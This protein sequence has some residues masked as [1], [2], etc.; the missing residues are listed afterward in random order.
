MKRQEPLWLLFQPGK[1]K[2][3]ALLIYHIFFLL[4]IGTNCA[5]MRGSGS[6]GWEV[7]KELEKVLQ[8]D[9]MVL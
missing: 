5:H 3:L 2:L 8:L 9:R 7:R 1:V 4:L 6:G